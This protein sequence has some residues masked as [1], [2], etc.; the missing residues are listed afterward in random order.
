MVPISVVYGDQNQP[1]KTKTKKKKHHL[2]QC[3]E[4][5]VL[6]VEEKMTTLLSCVCAY[7][8]SEVFSCIGTIFKPKECHRIGFHFLRLF[9][10]LVLISL[11]F[12]V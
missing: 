1:S 11:L 2:R 3:I 8:Y 4:Q 10:A 12:S 6:L 7:K 9:A 5:L